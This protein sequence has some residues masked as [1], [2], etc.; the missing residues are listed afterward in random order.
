M[1]GCP[2]TAA[3]IQTCHVDGERWILPH[4]AFKSLFNSGRWSCK[5]THPTTR[6]LFWPGS[7]L[8]A[9]DKNRESKSL[10]VLRV[11]WI[12]EGRLQFMTVRDSMAME[13]G[14]RSRE[15]FAA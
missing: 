2:L 6:T 10:V 13:S 1:V 7:W 8:S 5:V 9:A 12:C 14:L 3:A 4:L 11:R 15:V